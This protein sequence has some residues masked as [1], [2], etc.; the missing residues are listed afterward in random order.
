MEEIARRYTPA[1]CS[2]CME[3]MVKDLVSTPCGHVFHSVCLYNNQ[4]Y[5][6][7]CP[8]CRQRV[9]SM[10]NS[11]ISL[12]IYVVSCYLLIFFLD[13]LACALVGLKYEMLEE[14][15]SEKEMQ[16]FM[17]GLSEEDKLNIDSYVIQNRKLIQENTLLKKKFENINDDYEKTK[18]S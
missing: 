18:K 17:G 15:E 13:C 9:Q 6:S 8:L 4:E 10:K 14:N 7:M 2:I 12:K 1:E 11:N 3:Q 16:K 5:R